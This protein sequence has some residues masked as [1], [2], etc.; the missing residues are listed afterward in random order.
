MI[1]TPHIAKMLDEAAR[2]ARLAD[3][4]LATQTIP[5]AFGDGQDHL[6]S[7]VLARAENLATH[8]A[9][10]MADERLVGTLHL[11]VI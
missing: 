9:A 1:R 2:L 11:P 4:W 8:A 6:A 7:V 5:D 10:E 3:G